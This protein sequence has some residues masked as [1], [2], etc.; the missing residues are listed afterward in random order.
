M[1][2]RARDP[3]ALTTLRREDD[4]GLLP[5][6]LLGDGEDSSEELCDFSSFSLRR[7][8]VIGRGLDA[9]LGFV[10][11]SA[12]LSLLLLVLM[13]QSVPVLWCRMHGVEGVLTASKLSSSAKESRPSCN[14]LPLRLFLLCDALRCR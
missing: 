5:L 10:S 11:S 6:L 8:D 12:I 2:A 4:D 3:P 1:L 9:D 13:V 7:F 14:E